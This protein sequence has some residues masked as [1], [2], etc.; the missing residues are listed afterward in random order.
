M[1]GI[2]GI[3]AFNK[4]G[5]TFIDKINNSVS[6]MSLRGP[7]SNGCF[8]SGSSGLGHARLSIID[9]SDAA[10]QPF[11][12]NSGRYT[13]VL[14]GEIFNF[15]ELK[16]RLEKYNI[17][18]RSTS[19]TE[20]LLYLYIHEGPEIL[21]QLNG[22]FAFA[23]YDKYE[24]SIFVAR[25]RMGI[26]PLLLYKD[27]DKI[28]FASEMKAL[29]SFGIKKE[30]DNVSLYS[31]LQLN[32]I[33]G[34]FS[35]FQNIKKLTPGHYIKI[36]KSGV[37][38]NE[39]YYIPRQSLSNNYTTNISYDE[40]QTRLYNLLDE[41]VKRRL[42]SDVPLGAFLSGGVD[43]SVVVALA[44][45]YTDKLNTFS[46]GFKDEPMFDETYYANLVA[47]KFN[48]NHTVFSLS[49]DDL[50]SALFNVLDYIDEP[51]ADSSALAVYILSRHTRKHVTVALSG[52]GADEMFGGYMKHTGELK[53][54]NSGITGEI[55]KKADFIFNNIPQSRNSTLGNKVRQVNK[56]ISG[57][58][59]SE[60]ERYWKWC[61]YVGE[62]EASELIFNKFNFSDYH[63][64][65]NDILKYITPNGNFNEI[66][67]TDMNLVLQNDMLTKVDL[68]SMANSLEVRVPF[69]DYEVVN[70]AFSLPA[71]YKIEGNV[72]KRILQDA[73]RKILPDEIY[74][75]PKHGFEVPL[76]KWFRNELKSLI[77]D[78]LLSDKFIEEQGIFDVNEIVK[79]KNKLYSSNPGDVHAQIWGLLVFQ[80]WWKKY[81][82]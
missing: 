8:I 27:D 15:I 33:P 70:F 47:K 14:N 73:F 23:V 50:F 60:K 28:I 46:I 26:K 59:L 80:Y 37:V 41:S 4:N 5:E 20:V 52:D 65:K 51:F 63:S 3:Y 9:V 39:Y 71:N 45:K 75:R 81:F 34:P 43:S 42:I 29:L 21:N 32:Y 24:D 64:R 55:L 76:L 13:I 62:K 57:L 38:E 18:F 72:R 1:C 17:N 10:S 31:Y 77:S 25:D 74:H 36:S 54:R 66:L 79:I 11:T 82:I 58:K 49:N 48:T 44:S 68:M 16:K 69:L 22:F 30:I 67:Y 2:T 53:L 78:D 61:G 56:Y 40:A 19:D 6:A 35:I 7:D 12:D